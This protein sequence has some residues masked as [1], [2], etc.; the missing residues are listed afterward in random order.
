MRHYVGGGQRCQ[1]VDVSMQHK[2]LI[3]WRH[4]GLSQPC[5]DLPQSF[6]GNHRVVPF[7]NSPTSRR[8]RSTVLA[9]LLRLVNT[10]RRARLM[11]SRAAS[12]TRASMSAYAPSSSSVHLHALKGQT[13]SQGAA[14]PHALLPAKLICQNS[15]SSQTRLGSQP[16]HC[17]QRLGED[18]PIRQPLPP[19]TACT[20]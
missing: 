2:G 14:C 20:D 15:P 8:R 13:W 7:R 4:N 11:A 16:S 12:S 9:R 3:S 19:L 18:G 17:L 1:T 5:P 10:V 6:S